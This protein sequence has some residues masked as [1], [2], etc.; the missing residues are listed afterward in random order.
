MAVRLRGLR[1]LAARIFRIRHAGRGLLPD[2]EP[3]DELWYAPLT[4]G[5]WSNWDGVW[6]AEIAD[7]GYSG[8][9]SPT[10][11]VFFPLYPMLVR[12]GA[13]VLP[14]GIEVSGVG[15]SL[16]AALAGLFFVYRIAE[17]IYDEKAARAA[18]LAMAFFPTAFFFN[19]VYTEALFLAL[20][21]G[22]VWAALVRR[23]LLLAGALGDL[24]A[25]TRNPGVLLIP[26]GYE[27]L[28][29]REQFGLHGLAHPWPSCRQASWP[30][31][32]FC[33]R[34]SGSPSSSCASR[35]HTGDAS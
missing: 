6:Y 1:R 30:T 27:W 18:T 7:E 19:A 15:L 16:V 24:A 2:A 4:L 31:R 3:P 20:S 22:A 35:R 34:G 28:R 23:N 25:A 29:H 21:A 33:G 9:H 13:Y 32:L 17:E 5:Y 10:S 14:G 26:L 11:T 12:L 8:A